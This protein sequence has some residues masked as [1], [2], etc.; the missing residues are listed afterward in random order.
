MITGHYDQCGRFVAVA[1]GSE[2]RRRAG[3]AGLL[4]CRQFA[5]LAVH[6][7]RPPTRGDTFGQTSFLLLFKYRHIFSGVN[8]SINYTI[9][10]ICVPRPPI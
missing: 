5:L 2:E 7:R 1:I 6:H 4:A 8:I 3:S 9:L 10:I